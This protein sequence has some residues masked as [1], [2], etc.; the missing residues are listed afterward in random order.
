MNR[1]ALYVAGGVTAA[2][3]A[4]TLFPPNPTPDYSVCVEVIT[5]ATFDRWEALHGPLQYRPIDGLW[6]DYRGAEIGYSPTE[7]ADICA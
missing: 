6:L 2:V 3:A 1:N 5:D 7:D 4:F